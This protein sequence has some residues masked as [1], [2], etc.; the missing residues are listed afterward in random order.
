MS[1]C[2]VGECQS[3]GNDDVHLFP[4]PEYPDAKWCRSCVDHWHDEELQDIMI[5][6]ESKK[7]EERRAKD[8]TRSRV[9]NRR[10]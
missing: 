6:H 1:N 7:A 8:A 10:L 3:C 9:R 5:K 2:D 4:S